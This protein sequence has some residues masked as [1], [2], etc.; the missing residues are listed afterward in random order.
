[1]SCLYASPEQAEGRSLG[2][3]ADLWSWAVTVL[4]MFVGEH[5]WIS[6]AVADEVLAQLMTEPDDARVPIPSDVAE[7][8]GACFRADPAERPSLGTV[9]GQLAGTHAVR[10]SRPPRPSLVEES[11]GVHE[12]TLVSGARWNDPRG[13]LSFACE[14]GVL[15]QEQMI[16]LWPSRLGS[17]RSQA[18]E[19]LNAL[20][21]ADRALASLA[22]P[23][24][25]QRLV[26]AMIRIDMGH[27][28]QSLG[29]LPGAIE[30]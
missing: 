9:A 27:V 18:L 4:E 1:M 13:W 26:S 23:S 10:R 14:A 25:Q 7:L 19:D 28:H 3:A 2:G 22:A 30:D 12:R 20:A 24:A 16:R 11:L 5:T 6:G 21:E 15:D 29:D 8:L 17:R